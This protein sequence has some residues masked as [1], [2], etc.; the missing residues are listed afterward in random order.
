MITTDD[1]GADRLE[2]IPAP[3][4]D[5]SMILSASALK[6][7]PSRVPDEAGQEQLSLLLFDPRTRYVDAGL[8][9]NIAQV[10]DLYAYLSEWLHA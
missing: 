5:V 10:S 7:Y 8:R 9:L 3:G 1:T 2:I 6:V 4:N